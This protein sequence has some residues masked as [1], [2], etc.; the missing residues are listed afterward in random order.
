MSEKESKNEFW[1]TRRG[2]AIIKLGLW[3]IFFIILFA[4]LAIGNSVIKKHPKEEMPKYSFKLYDQMLEELLK[5]NFEFDYK[6][7]NDDDIYLFNGKSNGIKTEGIKENKDGIIKY[8]IE[9]NITYE[10]KL[11]EK[12]E[13][14]LYDNLNETYLNVDKLMKSIENINYHIEKKDGIRDILYDNGVI[15][16]TDERNIIKILINDNGFCYD[17]KFSNIGEVEI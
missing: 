4:F 9:D 6:I 13:V 2:K 1:Q 17:L 3:G 7:T 16:T 10:M 14:N 12:K 5:N 15:I 11:N 8:L